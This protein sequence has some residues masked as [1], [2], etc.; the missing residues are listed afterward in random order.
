LYRKLQNAEHLFFLSMLSFKTPPQ[1][2]IATK[3]SASMSRAM[4]QAVS[5]RHLTAEARVLARVSPCRIL[6]E[7]V[8]LELVSFR[9]IPLSSATV[10]PP[11]YFILIYHLWREQKA[12]L[13]PQLRDTVSSCQ[14]GQ[15]Q[16]TSLCL[17]VRIVSPAVGI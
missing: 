15:Q 4:T 17:H 14:R 13:W 1:L 16:Q 12:Y 8:A 6:V 10:I 2:K 5:H 7:K 3:K 9:F 11:W